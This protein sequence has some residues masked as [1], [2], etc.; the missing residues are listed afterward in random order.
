M[1]SVAMRPPVI[2]PTE[3]ASRRLLCEISAPRAAHAA[4]LADIALIC[5]R[6]VGQALSVKILPAGDDARSVLTLHL[7][8]DL[9]AGQHPVWCLACRLACFCPEARVSVLIQGADA[10]LSDRHLP[11]H[12][13]VA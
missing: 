4:S 1:L 12:S 9:A 2:P 5:A 8:V 3:S 13:R 7:P 10:F 11:P 6:D